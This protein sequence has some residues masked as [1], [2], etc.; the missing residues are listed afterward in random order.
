[1]CTCN[2][3]RYLDSD[4]SGLNEADWMLMGGA[5]GGYVASAYLDNMLVYNPD[6]TRKTTG[7][8]PVDKDMMRNA[9]FAAG[10]IGLAWFMP[11]EPLAKGAGIGALTY[12][13]KQMIRGQYPDAG[14]AGKTTMGQDKYVAGRK[15]D[16]QQK[17]I[18]SEM[19]DSRIIDLKSNPQQ[20]QSEKKQPPIIRNKYS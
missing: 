16:G 2:Q 10:G 4:I 17:Y 6:G 7:L 8:A 3:K 9:I 11:D 13:V 18:A 15:Q 1:M 5:V 12:G 14:I 19:R 20:Q